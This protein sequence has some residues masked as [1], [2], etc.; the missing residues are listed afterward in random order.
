MKET[1]YALPDPF[2]AC[3]GKLRV[4]DPKF[5]IGDS[6]GFTVDNVKM[7]LWY[8]SVSRTGAD[9]DHGRVTKLCIT[10][11]M[12]NW[13]MQEQ[14]RFI[15]ETDGIA[16]LIDEG[17]YNHESWEGERY[18]CCW[19]ASMRL[20]EADTLLCGASCRSGCGPGKYEGAAMRDVSGQIV[21]VSISFCEKRQ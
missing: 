18:D 7:G 1:S 2:W 14:Q 11:H 15:I 3:S 5:D 4:S 21:R 17:T 9:P 13:P 20:F 10:H 8:A 16:A 12:A 6:R 19:R